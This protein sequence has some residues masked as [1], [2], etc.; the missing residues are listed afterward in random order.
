MVKQRNTLY[1][2]F[3]RRKAR[4]SEN[5][6]IEDGDKIKTYNEHNYLIICHLHL[7]FKRVCDSLGMQSDIEN[8]VQSVS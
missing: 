5:I 7:L 4:L 6:N 3:T 8:L 1:L 2:Y